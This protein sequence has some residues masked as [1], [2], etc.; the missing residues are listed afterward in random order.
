ML[1][2]ENIFVLMLFAAGFGVFAR[3]ASAAAPRS[4]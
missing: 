1:T 4:R 3:E 2:L